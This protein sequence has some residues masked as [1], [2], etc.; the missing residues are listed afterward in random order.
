[1]TNNPDGFALNN[2]SLPA[3]GPKLTFA[4]ITLLL[5]LILIYANSLNGTWQF[6]DEPNIDHNASVHLRSL[7]SQS[8]VRTFYGFEQEKIYRPVA[9]LSFGL[10]HYFGGM[11]PVGYHIVN[12]AIH[13]LAAAFLFLFVYRT[14]TLPRLQR[15]YGRDAYPVALLSA[16]LWAINPVQVTAVTFIVQRM[17]S[18]AGLF[19]ILSMYLYVLGRTSEIQG[20]KILFFSLTALSVAL[21]MG[22]KENA[23]MIP[24]SIYL[25]DLILIQDPNR[26]TFVKHLKYFILP[27]AILVSLW[28]VFSLDIRSITGAYS[29]RPFTLL[30][31]LLTEPRV[32]LFYVSLLL[33]PAYSRLM[34]NHDFEVSKS[35]LEPWTTLP[36]LL[37]IVVCVVWAVW[38]ARKR[39][40]PVY[41]ILFFFLNHLIEGS[42]IPL[43]LIYEH[44]NYIPSMLLFLPVAVFIVRALAYFSYRRILQFSIAALVSF[45]LVAQGHTVTMY[46]FIFQAPYLLWSDNVAKAPNL[47]RPRVNLGNILMDMGLYEDAYVSYRKAWSLQR[48]DRLSQAPSAIY[49][50]GR[51]HYHKKDYKKA[52]AHFQAA[53]EREPR[54]SKLWVSLAQTQIQ[55][56]DLKAAENTT[57]KALRRGP[58]NV[59]LNAM[60]SFVLLK[61]EAY[62][63]AI[64]YAWKTLTI[65][66]KHTDV[67][68]VLG[69]AH[70]RTGRIDRAVHLW[71]R[72]LRD[73]RDDIEGHLA[74][75][76]LYAETGQTEKLDRT[77]AQVML[78]KESQSWRELIADYER[79]AAR[80]AYDADS[81]RLLSA[82]RTRLNQQP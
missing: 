53:V 82:I 40:L 12:L 42:F 65:D 55:L 21:A 80:H 9:Y 48:F 74:L 60:L 73:Y 43:E 23:V 29:G 71:E 26:E 38:A 19:Y 11:N 45:V 30:E 44:R 47:S 58:E 51:Y 56:G 67:L 64:R 10:N 52:L 75:I 14:L 81:Q 72:Y 22:T 1:M 77:I 13:F 49:N 70:R 25:Y 5:V 24:V 31:R 2:G 18:M 63:E 28:L 41:C 37:A 76:D 6:D 27:A 4:F 34:L 36:A 39:P 78:L 17:A 79:D 8:I 69:E 61:Q 7:D 59:R 68:R 16:F 35:M 3:S 66:P 50:L 33:Y 54:Y 15:T 20:K 62:A 32:I 57:R 46:N